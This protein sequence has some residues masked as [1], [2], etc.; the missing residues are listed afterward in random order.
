M[1]VELADSDEMSEGRHAP[2]SG[3]S[4]PPKASNRKKTDS[5]GSITEQRNSERRLGSKTGSM[6]KMEVI[7]Q[8]KS[9]IGI[10]EDKSGMMS[11]GLEEDS[12]LENINIVKPSTA[13]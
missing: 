9:H 11:D 7:K 13:Q 3:H 4:R 5:Q 12:L 8:N 10:D 6:S 2:P 1:E